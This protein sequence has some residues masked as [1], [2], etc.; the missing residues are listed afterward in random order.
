MKCPKLDRCQEKVSEE[1]FKIVCLTEHYV[2]C[3]VYWNNTEK[4]LPKQWKQIY[5]PTNV[6]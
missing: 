2:L 6:R 5:S 1:Y 4:K 3:P